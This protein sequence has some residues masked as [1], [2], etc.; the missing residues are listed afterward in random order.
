LSP[1]SRIL[2]YDGEC[3]FCDASVRFL[4]GRDREGKIRFAPLQGEFA[5]IVIERN[6]ELAT[7]DSLIWVE[8]SAEGERFWT[9]S[10]GA[11]RG[12]LALGGAWRLLAVLRWIPRPLRDAVY[13][14]FARVR[15]RIFGR[16]AACRI[17][18]AQERARFLE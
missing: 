3:G 10:E 1:L 6:P 2:L 8:Q 9:H 15:H 13:T 11:I 5:R 7:V 12:A 14:A 18:T 17:P 4:L 16:R